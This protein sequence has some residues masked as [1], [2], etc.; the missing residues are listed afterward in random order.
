MNND[1]TKFWDRLKTQRDELIVRA[2]LA[3][4]ELKDEWEALE[5]KWQQAENQFQH[6]QDE[7]IE[8]TEEMNQSA[9]I[10]M[11]EIS[12][13]YKNIKTRLDD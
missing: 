3:K 10:I 12:T 11:E 7:A 6:L 13:A 1:I 8:T 2:H 4:A 5:V 9:H